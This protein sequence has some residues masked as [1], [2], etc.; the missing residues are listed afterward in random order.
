MKRTLSLATAAVLIAAA[1]PAYAQG[2]VGGAREGAREGTV[3]GDRAGG[4]VGGIVGSVVGGAVGA[5]NG[6]VNGVLGVDTRPR[7]REY[8]VRERHPSYA[9]GSD[10]RVG[11]VLPGAGVTYYNAPSDYGLR[12]YRYTVIDNHTVIVDPA[13]NRV[14]EIVD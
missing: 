9:Y 10:L 14:V 13:T 3:T 12:D 7:F 5:A 8:V 1:V 2:I 4:T 11:A 6:V